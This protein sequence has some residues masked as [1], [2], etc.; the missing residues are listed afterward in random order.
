MN[1]YL[2]I[3]HQKVG[4]LG[5]GGGG[6]VEKETNIF[7]KVGKGFQSLWVVALRV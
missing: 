2:D 5:G 4:N 1:T 7:K 6:E 3:N